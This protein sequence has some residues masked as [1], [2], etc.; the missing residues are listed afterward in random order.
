VNAIRN[1]RARM[2]AWLADRR[3]RDLEKAASA[4]SRGA[5]AKNKAFK[6]T[7]SFTGSEGFRPTS[8]EEREW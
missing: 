5:T 7:A 6:R 1:M 8:G 3:E 2:K 4:E